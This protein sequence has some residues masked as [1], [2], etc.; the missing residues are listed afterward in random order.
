VTSLID[1]DGNAYASEVESM[2]VQHMYENPLEFARADP[3]MFGFIYDI[4]REGSVMRAAIFKLKDT[5]VKY[6]GRELDAYEAD[7]V[8]CS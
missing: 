2:G 7:R 1:W 5:T 8:I 3:D 4:L 6:D